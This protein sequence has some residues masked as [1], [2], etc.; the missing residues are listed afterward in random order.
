VPKGWT[1][2]LTPSKPGYAFRPA[3]ISFPMG[4]ASDE[5]WHNFVAG[6]NTLPLPVEPCDGRYVLSRRPLLDW[7]D[8]PGATAYNYQLSKLESFTTV[9]KNA[10]ATGSSY[11]PTADLLAGVDLWW[12]VR[13]KV[14][15]VYGAWS[16]K[17]KFHTPITPSTPV[18]KAPA[19]GSLLKD[20]TPLL[21]WA[22]VTVP[23]NA[24]YGFWRY[25]IEL[26][27]NAGFTT[28]LREFT[29]PEGD[30][31]AS[32]LEIPGGS[33]LA[34]NT[35][36][37]WHVR[38]ANTSGEYSA[39]STARNFRTAIA[40]PVLVSP[41]NTN[42]AGSLKPTFDWQD[43]GGATGYKIQFS[44]VPGFS[45]VLSQATVSGSTFTPTANL[46][47]GSTLY[48]RVQALGKNGPSDWSTVWMFTTP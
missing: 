10:T 41:G 28:G 38:A 19:S 17:C 27:T 4:V 45:A 42:P 14:G 9:L 32:S 18:L 43:A 16:E 40:P 20:Y 30:R 7:S 3:S 21:D 24:T 39:W 25:E 33:A 8:V 12:R 34:P 11:Q 26:A 5:N 15:G 35:P 37:Y 2:T 22:D 44:R 23:A 46:P 36:Y 1:G 29:T 6:Q 31:T 47:A 48:W 13:A